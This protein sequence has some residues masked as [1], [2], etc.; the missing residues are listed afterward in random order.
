[1]D[2][3]RRIRLYVFGVV[4]GGIAA[5]FIYGQRLTNTAWAPE[6]RVKLRL[7]STLVKT[8]PAAREAL[9]GLGLD[10]QDIREG[11]DSMAVRFQ[12][13]RRTDDSLYYV[14]NGRVNGKG[15]AFTAATLRNY[16]IDSTAT[17]WT[18]GPWP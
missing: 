7:R 6:A 17:L 18:V 2:L 11:L 15:I 12:E 3:G 10:L 4:L 13:S 5:Y 1:M 16:E 9:A 14:L 8:T